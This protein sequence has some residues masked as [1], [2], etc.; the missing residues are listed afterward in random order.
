[1]NFLEQ[2]VVYRVRRRCVLTVVCLMGSHKKRNMTK[3]RGTKD[4][5]G[6]LLIYIRKN[7]LGIIENLICKLLTFVES[8]IVFTIFYF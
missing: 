6:N 2:N 4:S 8:S 7:V 1:M 3:K 5:T